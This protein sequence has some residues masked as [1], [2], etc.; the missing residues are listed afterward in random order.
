MLGTDLNR[1]SYNAVTRFFPPPD[2][3]LLLGKKIQEVKT[4]NSNFY[5]PK[6]T[7]IGLLVEALVRDVKEYQKLSIV[8]GEKILAIDS[9]KH[10]IYT[11]KG[12]YTYDIVISSIPLHKM[13]EI[14]HDPFLTNNKILSTSKVFCLHIGYSEPIQLFEK[15]HW[16]YFS[17]EDLP[18]Y[19]IGFY[20]KFNDYMAPQGMESAYI[21]CGFDGRAGIHIPAQT[22]LILNHMEERFGF[23]KTSLRIM[24]CNI[25]YPGFV[26]YTHDRSELI[27]T[28][29]QK[30][31]SNDILQIGRYGLW[32][33]NSMED[34]YYSGYRLCLA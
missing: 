6:K 10:E 26:H 13:G 9:T 19:R 18:M 7:G 34:S 4:Y 1:I 14:V 15:Y 17:D 30:L 25:I 20:S 8:T 12:K 21:E 24:V 32:Y 5:Y 2:K 16:V 22:E 29:I 3:D 11:D 27:E 33:Y 31:R 28:I 23:K